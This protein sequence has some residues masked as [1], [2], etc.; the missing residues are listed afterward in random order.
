MAVFRKWQL[1]EGLCF[2][3]TLFYRLFSCCCGWYGSCKEL[4]MDHLWQDRTARHVAV[5][6]ALKSSLLA[7]LYWRFVRDAR[8]APDDGRVAEAVLGAAPASDPHAPE[9]VP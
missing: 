1:W 6:P 9:G 7:A 3:N 8:L 4:H 2:S 5:L